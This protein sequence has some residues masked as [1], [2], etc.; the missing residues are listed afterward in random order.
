MFSELYFINQYTFLFGNPTIAFTI[1]LSGILLFSGAGGYLSQKMNPFHLKWSLVCLVCVFTGLYIGFDH[2]IGKLLGLSDVQRYIMAFLILLP[3][4]LL[5][6][7]PFSI[8]MRL[9]RACLK[10][11]SPQP[12]L[13]SVTGHYAWAG[14]YFLSMGAT[15]IVVK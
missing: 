6:G 3:A 14:A 15:C 7:I 8:G 1:V 13:P 12:R 11:P 9:D 5:M 10:L 2:L 4:G